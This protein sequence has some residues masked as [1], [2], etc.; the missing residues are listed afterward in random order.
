VLQRGRLG[1]VRRTAMTTVVVPLLVR[2][3]LPRTTLLRRLDP[4]PLERCVERLDDGFDLLQLHADRRVLPHGEPPP[5][6]RF[7]ARHARSGSVLVAEQKSA[8]R[9]SC[10]MLRYGMLDRSR[11]IAVAVLAAGLVTGCSR[12][13]ANTLA[14]ELLGYWATSEQA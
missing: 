14:P 11:M 13:K 6:A 12:E 9:M 4:G 7:G 8:G 1:D 5:A 2:A 10:S 3:A